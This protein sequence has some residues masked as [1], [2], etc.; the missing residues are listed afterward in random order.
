MTVV[1]D[2]NVLV[3]ALLTNGLSHECFR[4]GTA[5]SPLRRQPCSTSSESTLR[6]KF[7]VDPSVDAFLQNLHDQVRLV[8]PA[9]LPSPVCRDPDDDLVLATAI[10]G[11]AELV[12]TSDQDLLVLQQY[13]GVRVVSPRQ[14]LEWLDAGVG[15][16]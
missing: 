7:A 9:P 4:G 10:S 1:F 14:F 11:R 8:D 6:R 15:S 3:A 2:T 13:E 5:R 16:T 12:G